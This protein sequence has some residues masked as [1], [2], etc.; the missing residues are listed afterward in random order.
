MASILRIKVQLETLRD[1]MALSGNLMYD[2]LSKCEALRSGRQSIGWSS[3][4]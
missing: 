3:I 4:L 2:W 1:E